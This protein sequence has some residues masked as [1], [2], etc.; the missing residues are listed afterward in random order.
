MSRSSFLF[1]CMF[2]SHTASYEQSRTP[3]FRQQSLLQFLGAERAD[4]GPK[5]IEREHHARSLSLSEQCETYRDQVNI[6]EWNLTHWI[7][8]INWHYLTWHDH[9]QEGGYFPTDLHCGAL[10]PSDLVIANLGGPS[11]WPLGNELA[12]AWIHA[13]TI[14]YPRS[15]E[16][17]CRNI[18]ETSRRLAS[19][20]SSIER[21]WL[22]WDR[23]AQGAA[24]RR[25]LA[26][27][28]ISEVLPNPVIL[29]TFVCVKRLGVPP[30]DDESS[31][32]LFQDI[33]Y[34]IFRQLS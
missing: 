29:A 33:N 2:Q 20:N 11:S 19:R 5:L 4:R 6:P 30:F 17:N 10:D 34:C 13:N 26:I 21:W 1:F 15:I 24:V 8:W 22:F 31:S 23:D 16:P 18:A 25:K 7:H 28:Q 32:N 3:W 27:L 14:Q 9:V 12:N